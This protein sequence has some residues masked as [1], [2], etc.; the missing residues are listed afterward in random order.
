MAILKNILK[1]LYRGGSTLKKIEVKHTGKYG[2]GVFATENFKRGDLIE[3]APIIVVSKN[4]W[5]E[6]RESILKNYVFRWG[7]DKALVLGYGVLYNHSFSPNG[8]YLSNKDKL[9][10]DF[11]A[12]KDITAG[13]EILINYNGDPKDQSALWFKVI[14]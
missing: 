6:M 13:E 2:R 5:E 1:I 4:E 3:S 7:D 11:Y 10:M 14:E 8:R 9:T 12:Y